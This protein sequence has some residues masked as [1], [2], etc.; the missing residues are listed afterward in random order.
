MSGLKYKVYD[1]NIIFGIGPIDGYSLRVFYRKV[2]DMIIFDSKKILNSTFDHVFADAAEL[3]FRKDADNN[4]SEMG[5]EKMRKEGNEK[6]ANISGIIKNYPDWNPDVYQEGLDN[7]VLD[8]I[9]NFFSWIIKN[10]SK[11]VLRMR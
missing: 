7:V 3:D 6:L 11:K 8:G 5:K 10:Y 4:L 9:E 2:K 1:K